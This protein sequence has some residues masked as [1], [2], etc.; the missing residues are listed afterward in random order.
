MLRRQIVQAV[1]QLQQA[2]ERVDHRRRLR[3]RVVVVSLAGAGLAVLA[4]PV[5]RGKLHGA[6]TDPAAPA[7]SPLSE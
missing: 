6:A 5:V 7:E 2:K 1:V 3:S 4:L